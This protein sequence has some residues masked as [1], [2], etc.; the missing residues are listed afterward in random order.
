MAEL[1]EE[2]YSEEMFKAFLAAMTKSQGK[3]KMCVRFMIKG[4]HKELETWLTYKQYLIFRKMD[5]LEYCKT[6]SHL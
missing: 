5:C 4:E 1:Q 3:K 2:S 6:I